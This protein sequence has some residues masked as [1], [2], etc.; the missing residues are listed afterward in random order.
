MRTI[1]P[2]G[3]RGRGEMSDDVK[4]DTNPFKFDAFVKS[5]AV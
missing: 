3:T 1:N 5:P 2:N 4:T